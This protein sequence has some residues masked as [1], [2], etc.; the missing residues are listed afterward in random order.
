MGK[1]SSNG[2]KFMCCSGSNALLCPSA[3]VK[4]AVVLDLVCWLSSAPSSSR[5]GAGGS[6]AGPAQR[7]QGF[8]NE[9][10]DSALYVRRDININNNNNNTKG[11]RA[12]E[13]PPTP[14]QLETSHLYN[15]AYL[16]AAFAAVVSMSTII[17][18]NAHSLPLN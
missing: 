7:T 13:S 16:A 2:S 3:L 6:T 11:G 10:G 12:L 18:S 9:E 14:Q 17:T 5:T 1:V 15:I 8:Y 4:V